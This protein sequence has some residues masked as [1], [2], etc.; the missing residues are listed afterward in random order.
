MKTRQPKL[1][2]AQKDYIKAKYLSMIAKEWDGDGVRLGTSKAE[3][4]AA[5]LVL[6]FL[7]KHSLIQTI[8]TMSSES[9]SQL[10]QSFSTRWVARQ[11][12]IHGRDDLLAGLLS[13]RRRKF[14]VQ[15][16]APPLELPIIRHPPPE[17]PIDIEASETPAFVG[18]NIVEGHLSGRAS[19]K[20]VVGMTNT[21]ESAETNEVRR[22]KNPKFDE[23]FN[24]TTDD[25]ESDE[26]FFTLVL[27]GK[28][29]ETVAIPIR[30]F[31]IGKTVDEWLE[32]PDT[33]QL[34]VIISVET[35]YPFEYE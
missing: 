15:Q 28:E 34:R 16:P 18:V 14:V 4:I 7:K 23:Y 9:D 31:P 26:L 22:T 19:S 11:L 30:S 8:S 12:Q 20:V 17:E 24:V 27:N 2:S 29:T 6:Q 21:D 35:D 3:L 33:T 10:T 32:F 25:I 5:D 1:T 13:K